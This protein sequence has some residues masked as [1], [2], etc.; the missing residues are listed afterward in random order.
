MNRLLILLSF[1]CYFFYACNDDCT[2]PIII[3]PTIEE[4]RDSC[5]GFNLIA[6]SFDFRKGKWAGILDSVE[7]QYY[8]PD[9]IWFKE[10]SLIGWTDQS[11]E[12]SFFVSYFS[13]NLLYKQ[14]W[15]SEPD[16]PIFPSGFWTQYDIYTELFRI[17]W[18][19]GNEFRDYERVD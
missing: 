8:I 10:D 2:P 17:Y 18:D 14:S 9:T 5:N 3:E 4:V 6:C 7:L 19:G 15:G 11:G 16:D 13:Q 12:F 1:W